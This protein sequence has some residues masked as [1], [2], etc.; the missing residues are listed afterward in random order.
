MAESEALCGKLAIM[1]NGVIKCVGSPLFIKDRYG[2]GYNVRFRLRSTDDGEKL[3]VAKRFRTV[4]PD[5]YL[6]VVH[7]LKKGGKCVVLT[8]HSMAESEA[9]CGKLAIMV[10]GVIKCVG[11][12]LFIKNRYGTG[13]NVRFRLRSTDGGEKLIVAKRFRTVFPDAYLLETHAAILHFELPPPC[14]LPKL[15]DFTSLHATDL[16]LSFSEQED[17]GGRRRAQSAFS[18]GAICAVANPDSDTGSLHIDTKSISSASSKTLKTPDS[19][20]RTTFKTPD[21]SSC[22]KASSDD[23][24]GIR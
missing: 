19:S 13:Y 24:T 11:S 20:S 4:F 9:L 8:S 17:P 12:P 2:T 16:V 10:N 14:D 15:F 18:T 7:S 23:D 22:T 1:V 21:S 5:A 3:I 6:L